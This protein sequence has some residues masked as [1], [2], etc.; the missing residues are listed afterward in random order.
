LTGSALRTLG[1]E[2]FVERCQQM[3]ARARQPVLGNGQSIAARQ[4]PHG[5]PSWNN[6]REPPRR[7]QLAELCSSGVMRS[8]LWARVIAG[9][10][11]HQEGR[12]RHHPHGIDRRGDPMFGNG[13]LLGESWS[14][15]HS[16][17][18]RDEP[19]ERAGG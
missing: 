12:A 6:L 16:H 10:S 18:A 14:S 15:M 4:V 3:R 7:V 9:Y 19:V 11:L 5:V 1:F 13:C 8:Q 17:D 2:A